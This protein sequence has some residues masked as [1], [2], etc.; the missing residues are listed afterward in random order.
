RTMNGEPTDCSALQP[1]WR[2]GIDVGGT[3]TDLVL[4]DSAGTSL[5]VKVPSVPVD[6]SRGVIA[7]LERL[8]CELSCSVSDV[9]GKCALFVHGSTV[10]TN[11][12]AEGKGAKVGLLTTEGFRDV[13]EIRRGLR[14]D[15]WNHRKPYAPVLVPRHL[16]KGVGGRIDKDGSE[17]APL[18]LD[19]VDAALLD[20]KQEGV[21]AVAVAFFNSFLDDRHEQ[22]TAAHIKSRLSNVWVTTSAAL[23]PM[24]GEYERTS[25]AVINAA[26][27]PGIVTYL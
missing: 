5:V 15:Q 2:I 7:A 22:A 3:F 14:E 11:R 16:R 20:F 12:M 26:L 6:P 24:M 19:D 9:L 8:A 13:L 23:T 27:A 17:H 21:E 10:A 1:P 25:T 4:T 18:V